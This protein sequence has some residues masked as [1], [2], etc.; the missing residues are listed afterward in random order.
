MRVSLSA[1]F[2][3]YIDRHF[4]PHSSSN[5]HY[6]YNVTTGKMRLDAEKKAAALE[7]SQN[8]QQSKMKNAIADLAK[9]FTLS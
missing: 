7:A 4:T 3:I 2:Q 9:E 6:I 8:Q 1:S 5:I